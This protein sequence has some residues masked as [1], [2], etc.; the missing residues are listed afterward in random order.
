MFVVSIVLGTDV[1]V[2]QAEISDTELFQVI[3]NKTSNKV[4]LLSSNEKY[5][6]IEKGVVKA[7][8]TEVTPNSEFELEWFDT[9]VRA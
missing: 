4:S 3:F 9:Q 2:N 6:V 7:T 1:K 8:A 5:W